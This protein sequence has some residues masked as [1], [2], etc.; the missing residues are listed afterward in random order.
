MLNHASAGGF[1]L[2][3]ALLEVAHVAVVGVVYIERASFNS[4]G[5][6][7]TQQS[8]LF[9]IGVRA[10]HALQLPKVPFISSK[11]KVKLLKPPRRE[12]P[13]AVLARV[14]SPLSHE[15]DRTAVSAIANVPTGCPC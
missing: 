15:A 4:L 14:V 3:E 5:V 12:L 7:F 11:D 2:C 13:S 6:E 8:D 10:D 1:D 9:A